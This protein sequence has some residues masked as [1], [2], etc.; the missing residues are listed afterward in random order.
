ADRGSFVADLDGAATPFDR[1]HVDVVVAVA[2]ERTAWWQLRPEE[3]DL[4]RAAR[5]RRQARDRVAARLVDGMVVRALDRHGTAPSE[6][7]AAHHPTA[8]RPVP[9]CRLASPR[10]QE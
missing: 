7:L 8:G 4:A 2:W 3:R 5:R 9:A 1:E 6:R 10:G